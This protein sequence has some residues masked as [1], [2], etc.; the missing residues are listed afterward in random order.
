MARLT[1]QLGYRVDDWVLRRFKELCR[2]EGLRP[3]QAVE[4][5]MQLT[6]Q[7]GSIEGFL[8]AVEKGWD[9]RTVA[10]EA[11]VRVLLD[12]LRKGQYWFYGE[13]EEEVSIQGQLYEMMGRISDP[14]LLGEVEEALKG[15]AE[16]TP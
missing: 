7:K 11:R 9:E 14:K 15:S 6:T 8:D 12:W 16:P 3:S 2:E 13:G 10:N 4:R 5:F 1:K